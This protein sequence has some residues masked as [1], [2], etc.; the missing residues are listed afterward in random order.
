FKFSNNESNYGFS[1]F[2][3]ID[4]FEGSAESLREAL[5]SGQFKK[6]LVHL[7]DHHMWNVLRDFSKDIEIYIW[8][9]GAEIQTW[10]RR[11]FEFELMDKAQ[12]ERQKRLSDQ[13]R[14]FWQ[15][16]LDNDINDNVHFIFVSQ[17]FLEESEEGLDRKFP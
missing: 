11:E 7:I 3:S 17:Y 9:H 2:E 16:M 12:I 14:R 8:V 1:E 10:Q 6:V 5:S 15:K 4:V 13:R